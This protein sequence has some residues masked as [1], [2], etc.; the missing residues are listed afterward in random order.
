M[1]NSTQQSRHLAFLMPKIDRGIPFFVESEIKTK[2]V[3]EV[4]SLL[5]LLTVTQINL[6]LVG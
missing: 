6:T 4:S 1:R 2:A 3:K 5:L